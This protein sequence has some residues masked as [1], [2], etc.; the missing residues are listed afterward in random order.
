MTDRIPTA[1]TELDGF[2]M[3][4]LDRDL[5]K[6]DKK[7]GGGVCLY[8]NKQRCHLGHIT[9]RER[10]SDKNIELLA[11][12]C[13]P[14]YLPREFSN[15]IVLVVYIPPSANAKHATDTICKVA[16]DLQ[17]RSPDA[18]TIINGD[19]NHCTLSSSLPSFRQFVTCPTRKDRTI[20]LFYA[21]VKES[22][23]S[24]ALPP[25]GCSD[26]NLVSLSPRY[27]PLV[28]R[29]PASTKSVR[30]WSDEACEELRGCFE[31]TDWSVFHDEDNNVD[32]VADCVTEYINFCVDMIIPC[33][34][35][36]SFP[37]NKPWVTR[38]IKIA[39]NNKKS[40]FKNGDKDLIKS[41]Q[42]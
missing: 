13:R 34:T 18:L 42:K 19:F 23:S 33:K 27:V 39:I 28:H 15:I 1:H 3:I 8:V 16:H 21:N 14:Y 40:A 22:F 9:E 25:L 38:E 10:V 36:K 5:E 29:Q 7:S 37:N 20:D 11:V 24:T 17:C 6:T 32:N 26:H 30:V 31:C 12:S 2:T 4:R 41:A 35:I